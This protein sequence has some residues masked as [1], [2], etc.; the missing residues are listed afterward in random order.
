MKFLPSRYRKYLKKPW[1]WVGLYA[2]K[3]IVLGTGG[4]LYHRFHT[5]PNQEPTSISVINPE[6]RTQDF[7]NVPAATPSKGTVITEA[8]TRLSGDFETATPSDASYYYTWEPHLTITSDKK[9]VGARVTQIRLLNAPKQGKRTI[10]T[11]PHVRTQDTNN[12]FPT[13][14]S[15]FASLGENKQDIIIPTVTTDTSP[16]AD[17]TGTHEAV[18]RFQVLTYNSKPQLSELSNALVF[19]VELLFSDGTVASRYFTK[20]V[21]GQSIIENNKGSFIFSQELSYGLTDDQF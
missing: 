8:F 21:S 5:E 12:L 13:R 1:F 11:A 3:L 4:Y 19:T 14:P 15:S 7:A 16:Y 20:Q 18:I 17:Y 10:V 2:C 6:L 9:I